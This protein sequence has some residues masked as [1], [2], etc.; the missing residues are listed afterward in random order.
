MQIL[1]FNVLD[2]CREDTR[3]EKMFDWLKRQNADVI[4][5][6][7]LNGWN[8]KEFNNEMTKLDLPHSHLFEMESSPYF[9]GIASKH[10]I[11]M[12]E[13]IED[14]PTYH[15][16]LHVKI[17]NV[18]FFIVHLTPFESTE[19]EKETKRIIELTKDI[20]EP[21]IVLGDFNTL[22]PLDKDQY[23]I[24]GTY[25]KLVEDSVLARLHIL[26][27]EINYKPMKMLLESGLNDICYSEDFHH[28][29]PSKIEPDKE[30]DIR[31]RIDYILGNKHLL[32][33]EPEC[34]FIPTFEVETLSDH[35][36]TMC[37]LKDPKQ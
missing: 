32:D 12:I 10:P 23:E 33:Y 1:Q 6:N 13:E 9:V 17:N 29:F 7:E 30:R 28:T 14:Y 25:E 26:N 5:F 20:E 11:E 24:M 22:S 34:K 3:Y 27:Q 35:Y 19:R 31:L 18:H 21:V 15:G 8:K 16:L 37:I 4:A 36:P 2:G